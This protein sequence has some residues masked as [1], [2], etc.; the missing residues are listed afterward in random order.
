MPSASAETSSFQHWPLLLLEYIEIIGPLTHLLMPITFRQGKVRD[1]RGGIIY[2]LER[3]YLIRP[4]VLSDGIK[5]T[6]PFN[7]LTCGKDLK[8]N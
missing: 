6:I 5:G 1:G 3:V 2:E 8:N 7:E 4:F